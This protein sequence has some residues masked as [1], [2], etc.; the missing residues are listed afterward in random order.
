MLLSHWYPPPPQNVSKSSNEENLPRQISRVAI[1]LR[2]KLK[3]LVPGL[4]AELR[5][6]RLYICARSE[7]LP[8]LQRSFL[9]TSFIHS[10]IPLP[11]PLPT[12]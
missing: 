8:V 1:K 5:T 12:I 7:P 11:S 10:T 3:Q 6:W 2:T 4:I 9:P